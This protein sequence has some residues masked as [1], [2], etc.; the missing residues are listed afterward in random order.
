MIMENIEF[1]QSLIDK[2]RKL[3]CTDWS[4]IDHMIVVVSDEDVKEELIKIQ[5]K[6]FRQEEFINGSL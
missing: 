4:L 6:K 1:E 3:S 2:A 5:K